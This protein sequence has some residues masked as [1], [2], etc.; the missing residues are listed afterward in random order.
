MTAAANTART[1]APTR[2]SYLTVTFDRIG[3]VPTGRKN[4][5]TSHVVV[6]GDTLNG[7]ARRYGLTVAQLRTWNNT[8]DVPAAQPLPAGWVVRLVPTLAPLTVHI[9]RH[10]AGRTP[11]HIDAMIAWLTLPVR[12]HVRMSADVPEVFTVTIDLDGNG[13]GTVLVNGGRHGHATIAATT[14]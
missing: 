12:E 14:F 2:V 7:I 4:P 10:T 1:A 11:D 5:A 13:D 9:P 6:A 8:E 3:P